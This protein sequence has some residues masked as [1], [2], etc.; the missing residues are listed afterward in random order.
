M[1]PKDKKIKSTHQA[2]IGQLVER[3]LSE[4]E[5]SGSNPAAAPYQ[6]YKKMV[7][8]APLLTL[9]YTGVSMED[10]VRHVRICQR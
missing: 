7:L 4:Q 6:R 1:M 8:A 2:S 3:P 10:R 5:A 9:A